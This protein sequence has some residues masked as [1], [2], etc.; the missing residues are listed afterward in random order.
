MKNEESAVVGT[1]RR[2]YESFGARYGPFGDGTNRSAP[3]T[4]HSA[5]VQTVRRWY[6][7]FGARYE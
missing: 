5:M 2:R 7:P 1:V 4:N 3:G 6:G